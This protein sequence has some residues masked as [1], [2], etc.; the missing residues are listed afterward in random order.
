MSLAELFHFGPIVAG[1]IVISVGDIVAA[2]CSWSRNKS[3]AWA[4]VHGLILG[5]LYVIYWALTGGPAKS[6]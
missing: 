3:V 6:R 5:W 2:A 1:P 4:L